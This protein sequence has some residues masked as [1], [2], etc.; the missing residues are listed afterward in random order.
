MQGS[1][2]MLAI[3]SNWARSVTFT[4]L[5]LQLLMACGGSKPPPLPRLPPDA[6]ILAF[7]DSLTA[8]NGASREQAYPAQL[9][10]LIRREVIN[11][12]VPGETTE[13]G[14]ARLPGVLDETRPQLVIL[15]EGGNDMLRHMDA[16]QMRSNLAA[17]I[18]LIQERRIPLVL[19]A[20]PTPRLMALNDNPAYAELAAEFKL[21][22]L[23]D[24]LSEILKDNARKADQIHPNAAGYSDLAAAIAELLKAAG[25]V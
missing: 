10:N 9:S 20:V 8:G 12:G 22:L 21:P 7:G 4:L 19:L 16:A 15:C 25:A 13:G 2:K 3:R 23:K 24:Q 14:L 6:K 17:M 1:R 18:R 5:A 11:A